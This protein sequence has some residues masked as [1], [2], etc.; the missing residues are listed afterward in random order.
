[1]SIPT[2]RCPDCGLFKPLGEYPKRCGK[3]RTGVESYCKPCKNARWR[4]WAKKPLGPAA[5]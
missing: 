5:A 1:M 3:G 4:E 2:K